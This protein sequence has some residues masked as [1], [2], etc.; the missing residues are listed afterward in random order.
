MAQV[1]RSVVGEVMI[2]LLGH[3]GRVL[4]PSDSLTCIFA[5]KKKERKG[6]C[7]PGCIALIQSCL[8]QTDLKIG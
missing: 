4:C 5:V 6:C 1:M 2:G 7:V 8:L 3:C